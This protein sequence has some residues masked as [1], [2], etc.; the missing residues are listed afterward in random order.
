MREV[1]KITLDNYAKHR[2]PT[3]DFLRACLENNLME[4]MGRADEFSKLELLEICS[5]IYNNMPLPCHGSPEKVARWLS[6]VRLKNSD[7]GRWVAYTPN[8]ECSKT[9]KGRIKGFNDMYVFVV[10]HCDNNWDD[11]QNYTGESVRIEDI[12]FV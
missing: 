12:K 9:E 6:S 5:Y 2:I 8:Y 11:Y 3:G 1:T 10:F 7:I 4:A